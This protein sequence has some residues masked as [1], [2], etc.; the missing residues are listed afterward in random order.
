MILILLY[1]LESVR[2][3]ADYD[4]DAVINESVGYLLL[5]VGRLVNALSTEMA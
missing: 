5:P 2:V 1:R 4:V 3:R